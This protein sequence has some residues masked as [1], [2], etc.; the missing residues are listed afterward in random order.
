MTVPQSIQTMLCLGHTFAD[1]LINS[2]SPPGRWRAHTVQKSTE[3][4]DQL[5]PDSFYYW[6]TFVRLF[7]RSTAVFTLVHKKFIG[8]SDR[9]SFN[10]CSE[11]VEGE[12]RS[13]FG[14]GGSDVLQGGSRLGGGENLDSLQSLVAMVTAQV[15]SW[16]HTFLWLNRCQKLH[17]DEST[18]QF[19]MLASVRLPG[20]QHKSLQPKRGGPL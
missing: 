3:K 12:S 5:S 1:K 4:N 18:C 10:G 2:C 19:L 9:L 17:K 15:H 7:S 6:G 16:A 14:D 13:K 11:E 8:G 20:C